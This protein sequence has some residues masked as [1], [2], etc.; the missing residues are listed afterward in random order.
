MKKKESELSPQGVLIRRLAKEKNMQLRQ[1][2]VYSGISYETI[3][4]ISRPESTNPSLETAIKLSDTFNCDMNEYCRMYE[5][6]KK[7]KKKEK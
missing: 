2:A 7:E 3:M 5:Q 1:V 4:H 6:I